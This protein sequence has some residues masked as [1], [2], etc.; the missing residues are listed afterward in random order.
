[1]SVVPLPVWGFVTMS[2]MMADETPEAGREPRRWHRK[3]IWAWGGVVAAGL[4]LGLAIV[5]YEIATRP[6]VPEVVVEAVP[7]GL[8]VPTRLPAGFRLDAGSYHYVPRE[9]TAVFQAST[10]ADD[11]IVFTEQAKPEGV[12]VGKI[13]EQQMIELKTLSDVPYPSMIGK[14]PDH[15]T[16][17][18]SVVAGNTWIMVSTQAAVSN[19]DLRAIALGLV[20]VR[21]S[22]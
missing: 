20:R 19:E 9:G 8:F 15:K 16:T 7:F 11:H 17:L 3:K 2:V 21:R 10:K 18:L 5:G 12:D 4:V 6:R 13:N 22:S 1:M 14:T